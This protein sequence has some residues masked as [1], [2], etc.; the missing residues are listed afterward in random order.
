MKLKYSIISKLCGLTA[1]EMDLLLYMVRIQDQKTGTVEG[2]YYRDVMEEAGMCK[3]S[4]YN[5]LRGLERKGIIVSEKETDM[6]YDIQILENGFPDEKEWHKGYVKLSRSAFQS[7]EFRGLKAHEKYMLLEFLKGTHEN[8]HSLQIG[9]DTLYQKF[10]GI[11]GVSKRVIR[12]YLHN[13]KKFFSIGV[14]G[15]KYY[16]TYLHS[17]FREAHGPN[18]KSEES[19]YLEHLVE[20]ECWRKHITGDEAAMED[21]AGLVKQY[22]QIYGRGTEAMIGLLM[23]CVEYSVQG[24]E[25]KKRRLQPKY[26]NKLI[27]EAL[28]KEDGP[29]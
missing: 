22:R 20:K 8:G 12:G 25:R 24:V 9:A 1:K 17:V 6:D 4:F 29:M 13:L 21:T 28:R 2:V 11:L 10:M 18:V 7:K 26:I 16:I 15:G 23:A 3:Q 5:A 14:R 19:I 27:Q